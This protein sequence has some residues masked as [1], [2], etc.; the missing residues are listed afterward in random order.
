ME[1]ATGWH[2]RRQMAN[3]QHGRAVRNDCLGP[4][5]EARRED[6]WED[7]WQRTGARS[8]H[9]GKGRGV[10]NETE[11][12]DEQ[13]EGDASPP[14]DNPNT[15]GGQREL[16]RV[17]TVMRAHPEEPDRGQVRVAC[18]AYSGVQPLEQGEHEDVEEWN[19]RRMAAGMIGMRLPAHLEVIDAEL[20]TR[21]HAN[22]H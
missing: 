15:G 3:R 20:R 4:A 6:R 5:W 8:R 16:E 14:D 11:D 10:G 17:G 7:V 19:A 13:G 2:I 22:G 18:G 9:G 12:G 1:E 21:G